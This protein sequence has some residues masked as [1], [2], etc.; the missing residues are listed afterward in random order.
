ME[1]DANSIQQP[2]ANSILA[3][4]VD[5]DLPDGGDNH[6]DQFHCRV[7]EAKD[8]PVHH[9]DGHLQADEMI[10]LDIDIDT[11]GTKSTE[12][13]SP[14]TRS[15]V[16]EEFNPIDHDKKNSVL[17]ENILIKYKQLAARTM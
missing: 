11:Q 4:T 15:Q 8:H 14:T 5:L 12:N 7:S 16:V 10:D 17:P 2:D 3:S 1:P 6:G 13:C 9:S